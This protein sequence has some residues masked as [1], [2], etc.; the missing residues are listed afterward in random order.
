M[1]IFI[2][3]RLKF[4][5][6]VSSKRILVIVNSN[7]VSTLLFLLARVIEIEATMKPCIKMVSKLSR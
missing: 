1:V 5:I 2:I 7:K 4:E 6:V 3:S